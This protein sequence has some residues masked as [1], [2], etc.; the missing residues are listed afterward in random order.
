MEGLFMGCLI[1][2]VLF[3]VVSVLIGDLFGNWLD[4]ILD[5][6]HTDLFKPVIL[7]GGITGFGGAGLLLERYSGLKSTAVLLLAVCTALVLGVLVYFAYVKPAS[8]SENSTGYSEQELP[9]K[10]G[11]TTI[12]IPEVGYGEVMV[13]LVGGNVLHIAASWDKSAIAAGTKVVVI[14][15]RDGIVYVSALE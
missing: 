3:A 14:V 1:G 15:V 9:G 13:R 4:G 6:M 5:F 10:I 12:P 8:E 7:A 2:G 11:E